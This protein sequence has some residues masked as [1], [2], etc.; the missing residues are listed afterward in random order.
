[1]KA[2]SQ[3]ALLATLKETMQINRE[4]KKAGALAWYQSN[5]SFEAIARQIHRIAASL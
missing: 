1:M 4:E 2:G 5:L 3:A